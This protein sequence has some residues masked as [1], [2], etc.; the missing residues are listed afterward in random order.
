[1]IRCVCAAHLTDDLNSRS[2]S[3]WLQKRKQVQQQS[4][5]L[6]ILVTSETLHSEKSKKSVYRSQF[7]ELFNW[8][9]VEQ[10]DLYSSF[11]IYGVVVTQK[12]DYLIII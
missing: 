11:F 2:P 12:M 6:H 3:Y 7:Y 4:F 8:V 10:V 5:L 9:M 1:M